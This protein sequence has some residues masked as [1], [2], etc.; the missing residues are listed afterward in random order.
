MALI[1]TLG[2]EKIIEISNK[3]HFSHT[4]DKISEKIRPKKREIDL[5]RTLCAIVAGCFRGVIRSGEI[6]EIAR[7]WTIVPQRS[8]KIGCCGEHTEFS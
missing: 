2:N 3:I 7:L 8:V 5:R 4:T 6:I 1:F